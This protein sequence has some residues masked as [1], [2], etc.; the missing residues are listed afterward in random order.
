M[1]AQ[2]VVG[3]RVL[4]E[5]DET[6]YPSRGSWP[7]YRGKVGTVVQV[8]S[9]DDE[10]GVVLGAPVKVR[11]DRPTMAYGDRT[12]VWFRPHELVGLGAAS[13][14]TPGNAAARLGPTAAESP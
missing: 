13:T 2:F 14:D 12:V 11:T 8:N 10:I 5:R 9:R 4:I 7:R 1:T 3:D 6:L